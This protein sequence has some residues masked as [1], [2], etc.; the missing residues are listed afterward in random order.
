MGRLVRLGK[1][2]SHRSGTP[3]L[4]GVAVPGYPRCPRSLPSHHSC[5]VKNSHKWC[6][7][8]S[9]KKC[10]CPEKPNTWG[11]HHSKTMDERCYLTQLSCFCV[12]TFGHRSTGFYWNRLA[13]MGAAPILTNTRRFFIHTQIL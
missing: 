13:D 8:P 10:M 1:F 3:N 9:S 5:W 11:Y 2:C 4:E 6:P 7:Q 12:L